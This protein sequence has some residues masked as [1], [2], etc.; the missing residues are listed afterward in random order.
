MIARRARRASTL[1]IRSIVSHPDASGMSRSRARRRTRR[2][3]PPRPRR[4]RS[5]RRP[6]RTTSI[7]REE[8]HT[9]QDLIVVHVEHARSWFRSGLHAVSARLH[10]TSLR[11]RARKST[12]TSRACARRP[13]PHGSF[14]SSVCG[15]GAC[16][17]PPACPRT[18]PPSAAA[19]ITSGGRG[20]KRAQRTSPSGR[21]CAR[22]GR[23]A[24]RSGS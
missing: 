19:L 5:R 2:P 21:W 24:P 15:F 7:S 14:E 3:T 20:W 10:R 17:R 22:Q 18:R 1:P 11:C 9:P 13:R 8:A 12:A 4:R 16:E 6:R 23:A